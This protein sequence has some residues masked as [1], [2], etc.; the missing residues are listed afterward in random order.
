[1]YAVQDAKEKV[2]R[3]LALVDF[4]R[5]ASR[6]IVS[7]VED[8]ININKPQEPLTIDRH[9]FEIEI[10]CGKGQLM[11]TLKGEQ[12]IYPNEEHQRLK[13]TFKINNQLNDKIISVLKKQ[14]HYPLRTPFSCLVEYKGYTALATLMPTLDPTHTANP[15]HLKSIAQIAPLHKLRLNDFSSHGQTYTLVQPLAAFKISK[16]D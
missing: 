15:Q 8:Y 4:V 5:K 13:Q 7:L 3:E 9:M 12:L 16:T 1:M 6:K 10:V 11:T 14:P 2:A